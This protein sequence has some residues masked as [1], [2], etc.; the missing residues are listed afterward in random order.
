MIKLNKFRLGEINLVIFNLYGEFE[1]LFILKK[2][3]E[4]L[5]LIDKKVLAIFF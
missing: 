2:S 1:T 5:T 4:E 3:P